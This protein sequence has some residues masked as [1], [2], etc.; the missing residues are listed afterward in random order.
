MNADKK[1]TVLVVDDDDSI[2]LLLCSLL[3]GEGCRAVPARHGRE[4][5]DLVEAGLP[6]MVLLDIQM[7]VLDGR[8]FAREF[9]GRYNGSVPIVVVSAGNAKALAGEVGASDWVGKPFDIDHL[10]RVVRA[11]LKA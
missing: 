2:R 9:H 8:G 3:E 10:L 4:A 7:P 11:H 6:D 5:L 1:K